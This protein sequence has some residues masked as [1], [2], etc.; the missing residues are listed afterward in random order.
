MPR[1][2]T[3]GPLGTPLGVL[4]KPA[5]A[6]CNLRCEYCFYHGRD[7]DPYSG[8]ENKRVMSYDVLD[9]FL[10]EYLPMAGPTPNFGWQGGE[11]TLAGLPFFE[12]VV[13]RQQALKARNQNIANALQSNCWLIDE[14]W[15]KFLREHRF[16][17]GASIDGPEELNDRYRITAGGGGTFTRLMRNINTM[18]KH[19]VAVNVLT[20]VNRLTA[21]RPEQI[22]N[23]FVD[24]GF[25]WLQFIPAVERHPKT[26]KPTDFSVKPAQYGEFLCRVFDCWWNN[27]Q[28][29]V[30]VRM[31]DEVVTAVMGQPPAMCQLQPSCGAYV[32]VEYNGDVF[33]CDFFVEDRWKLGNL[34]EEPLSEMAWGEGM[35]RFMGIKPK[36]SSRC[37][38]CPWRPICHNGCPHYR[39]LPG[40]KFLDLDYL[41]PGYEKFYKHAVPRIVRTLQKAQQGP[42]R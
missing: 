26:G 38:K 3:T 37:T 4:V 6:D 25:E 39:A 9:R 16:L 10:S 7:T 21:Q 29:K 2:I 14:D 5:S 32:V 24:E 12:R 8:Q 19:D 18:R 23:F 27:G 11:P 30:S 35:K 17:V 1:T 28:P 42:T 40:R 13:E 36:A 22:F 41:C 20:V 15:A 33:P 31:F 34:T